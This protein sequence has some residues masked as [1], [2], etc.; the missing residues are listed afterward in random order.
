MY[1]KDKSKL[2]AY[3]SAKTGTIK[4]PEGTHIN[5]SSGYD[6]N[7]DAFALNC[8]VQKVELPSSFPQDIWEVSM[9]CRCHNLEEV[10]IDDG[11]QNYKT[12]DGVLYNHDVTKL[13]FC[14]YKKKEE[15]N[16]PSTV[17]E[18]TSGSLQDCDELT[19][20]Q[21][22]NSVTT[23]DDYTLCDC[24]KIKDIFL[25]SSVNNIGTNSNILRS[26]K[27][28]LNINVDE[29]NS[30]FASENGILY[31]KDKT[32]IL[33][34]PSGRTGSY[35]VPGDIDIDYS[36]FDDSQLSEIN[37]PDNLKYM[38]L[39]PFTGGWFQGC[40]NLKALNFSKNNPNYTSVDGVVYNKDLSQLVV[41]PDG[42]E[43]LTIPESVTNLYLLDI[44]DYEKMK[45]ITFLNKNIKFDEH[46]SFRNT[47]VIKGYTGSTAEKYAQ[48]KGLTFIPL[49]D[50]EINNF[51]Y[52]KLS[53]TSKAK[54]ILGATASGEGTLKYRFVV[55]N[56][57]GENVY[58]RGF[59][60]TNYTR[61]KPTKKG[62][63]TIYCK[64]Q[65]QYG[66]QAVSS[67]KYTVK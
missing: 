33:G 39:N 27:G 1:T 57:D 9:L 56:E 60:E 47:P 28:L 55:L 65:D 52:R 50:V 37:L 29:N 51:H 2:I 8:Q 53:N 58:T 11:N 6:S 54:I 30:S 7:R 10:T 61:W 40:T 13:L 59:G 4:I 38:Y 36:I 67:F 14:P 12:I 63:Y 64:V 42:K 22:T 62:N 44:Y 26:C 16:I 21:I 41:C 34:F 5:V 17:Q 48:E 35:T 31:D 25:P 23:I 66:R 18:L 46:F 3:P 20:I 32:K 15:L 43:N 19:N 49:K 24:D 45:Q